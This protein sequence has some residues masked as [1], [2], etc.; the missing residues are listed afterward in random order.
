MTE[1]KHD[2]LYC[3]ICNF[4]AKGPAQWLKHIETEKHKRGG[5]K[6][7]KTCNICNKTFIK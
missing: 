7:E 2:K 4:Q 3:E 6:K 1:I 5:T